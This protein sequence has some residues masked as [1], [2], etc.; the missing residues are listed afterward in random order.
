M[1][2][3]MRLIGDIRTEVEVERWLEFLTDM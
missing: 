3:M 2:S 1:K